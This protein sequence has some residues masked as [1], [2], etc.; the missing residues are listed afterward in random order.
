MPFF[1][2]GDPKRQQINEGIHETSNY[3]KSLSLNIGGDERYFPNRAARSLRA[4]KIFDQC[5]VS[6][7]E[8]LTE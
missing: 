7:K 8:I 4:S 5:H 2:K 1:K 3:G 6:V